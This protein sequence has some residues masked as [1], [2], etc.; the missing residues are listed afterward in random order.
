MSTIPQ[1]VIRTDYERLSQAD[2]DAKTQDPINLL[3]GKDDGLYHHHFAVCD[4]DRRVLD[5]DGEQRESAI[6][7]EMHRMETDQV[8][9]IVEGLGPLPAGAHVM[10]GGSGRG[11]TSFIIARSLQANVTGINFC[12]HHIEFAE[13]IARERGWSNRVGF[14]FANMGCR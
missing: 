7:S 11:G 8:D 1:S 10:D 5:G 9:L 12:R 13:Q 3:L 2:W 6:L 4:F 14:H